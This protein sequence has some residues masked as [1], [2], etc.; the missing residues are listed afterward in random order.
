MSDCISNSGVLARVTPDRV[1][2]LSSKKV[3]E[4]RACGSDPE[5]GFRVALGRLFSETAR[6]LDALAL[7]ARE[8]KRLDEAANFARWV[9]FSGVPDLLSRFA[10]DDLKFP[11]F[12][13][14][15]TQI[16]SDCGEHFRGGR[17]VPKYSD[18]DIA[19][20]K[21]ELS[22]IRALLARP[23][24]DVVISVVSRDPQPPVLDVGLPFSNVQPEGV[25]GRGH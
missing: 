21:Q 8:G 7:D 9:R 12:E 5:I 15:V 18:S 4:L 13:P 20:I 14:K 16:L 2:G 19:A 1:S 24:T 22:E 23:A 25:A 17:V 11:S 3:A 6:Y 10:P